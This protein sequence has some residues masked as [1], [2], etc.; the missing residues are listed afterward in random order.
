MRNGPFTSDERRD[1]GKLSPKENRGEPLNP[2]P[3]TKPLITDATG[4]IR[5]AARRHKKGNQTPDKGTSPVG[6]TTNF[7]FRVTRQIGD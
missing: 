6:N 2:K 7:C 1:S 3:Y 4:R 5:H